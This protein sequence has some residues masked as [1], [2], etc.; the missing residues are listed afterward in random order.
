M[1]N[2]PQFMVILYGNPPSF[3]DAP[4][5]Q[6]PGPPTPRARRQSHWQ[7]YA[8]LVETRQRNQRR[9]GYRIGRV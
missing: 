3:L 2:F 9:H 5:R 6:P 7:C 1:R 8:A 4:Q